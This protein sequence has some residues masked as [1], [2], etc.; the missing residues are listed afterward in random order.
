MRDLFLRICWVS[1][2]VV[3]AMHG[4]GGLFTACNA[5]LWASHGGG[6]F[7]LHA[8]QSA[9]FYIADAAVCVVESAAEFADTRP[10]KH[11]HQWK[12]TVRVSV[13]R[14]TRTR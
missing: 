11:S 5:W 8:L 2:W 10:L 13:R 4:G 7:A 3:W 1:V 12:P 9:F 6:G 14:S